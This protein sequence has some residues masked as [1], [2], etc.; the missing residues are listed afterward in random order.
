MP[1]SWQN[2]LASANPPC[3]TTLAK[4]TKAG[5][6]RKSRNGNRIYFQADEQ[7]PVFPGLKTLLVKTSGMVD[8]LHG[9]LWPMASQIKVAA[10]YGSIATGSET[11]RSDVDLLVV[12]SVKMI[13]L[14]PLLERAS[15][16]L[17]REI[18][19]TIY[20]PTELAQKATSSHFVKSVLGKPLLFILGTSSGLEAISGGRPD[21]RGNDKPV[22]D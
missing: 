7:C 22:R 16:K 2:T 5:I 19:P 6:L 3:N 10:V 1:P 11:S 4:F 12:G 20:T 9:E 15:R 17:R 14:V 21:R 8:V 18:N 13:D